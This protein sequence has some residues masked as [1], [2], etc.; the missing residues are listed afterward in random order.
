MNPQDTTPS[1]K[2][3][4]PAGIMPSDATIEFFG[5]RKNMTVMYLHSGMAHTWKQLPKAFYNI[6]LNAYQQDNGGQTFLKNYGVSLNRQVELYTYFCYGTLDHQPDILKGILQPPENFRHNG[7]CPS[8]TFDR[9]SFTINRA[10]LTERDLL[11]IDLIAKDTPDKVIAGL[12][13][14]ELSTYNY[15]K[16]NLFKK[17]KTQSRVGLCM[18]AVKNHLIIS[19]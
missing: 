9:K 14:I 5:I 8:I 16:A 4:L 18:E 3:Q 15:H 19:T 11:I 6:M 1:I 17:T 7:N 13:C 2:S 10:P 12:L